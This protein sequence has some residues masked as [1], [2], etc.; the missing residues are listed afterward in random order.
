MTRS[1]EGTDIDTT[2]TNQSA[3]VTV[4]LWEAPIQ[5]LEDTLGQKM[6]GRK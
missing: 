5:I 6:P 4:I 3:I 2:Q 1:R